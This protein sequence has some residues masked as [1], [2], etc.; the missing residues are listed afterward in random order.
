MT[1]VADTPVDVFG[2]T[3]GVDT[4]ADSHVAAVIDP[5]GRHLGEASFDTTPSGFKAL[6]LGRD[7]ELLVQ[8][9]VATDRSLIQ[10]Q[11]AGELSQHRALDE[12]A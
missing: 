3:L 5:V 11:L 4:H 12:P 2:V 1:I 8:G 7:A 9:E 6:G 10:G